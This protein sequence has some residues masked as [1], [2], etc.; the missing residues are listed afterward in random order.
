MNKIKALIIAGLLVLVGC[1]SSK[2]VS[3]ALVPNM[4]QAVAIYPGYT[5][6][7]FAEGEK[8][9]IQKCTT[10]H[11]KKEATEHNQAEWEKIVP[12]MV[13]MANKKSTTIDISSKDLILKY[14]VTMSL[15]I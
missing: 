6:E 1:H 9:Y 2:Q 11:N 7:Q 15:S 10:S 14:L 8:L 3:Q 12:K 5:P 13:S 4:A